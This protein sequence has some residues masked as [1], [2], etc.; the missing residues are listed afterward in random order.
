MG[1]WGMSDT[2][3]A[4]TE[5]VNERK[6]WIQIP[7]LIDELE[8]SPYAVRLYLRL[9]RRAGENGSCYESSSNLAKGCKMSTHKVV[10]AKRE[11]QKAGLISVY[12]EKGKHGG[13]DY[14]VIQVTDIWH[15]N[16][17]Y[18]TSQVSTGN[19]QDANMH[20]ARCKYAM[21][22]EPI[23]KSEK[24]EKQGASHSLPPSPL[25]T[26]GVGDKK[27]AFECSSLR[28]HPAIQAI[29]AVTGRFPPRGLY[30]EVVNCLGESPDMERLSRCYA[31]CLSKGYNPQNYG[32]WLFDWYPND[33]YYVNQADKRVLEYM[34][35]NAS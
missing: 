1:R 2:N 11:L 3:I 13:R 14:H 20:L 28:S 24:K 34:G 23:K 9:K 33:S 35:D 16:F 22:E 10:D 5:E 30:K 21:K 27:P 15:S 4:V 19:L 8:L 7:N 31:L 12:T 29:K 6:Y 26:K 18:F 17:E 25:S 32:C